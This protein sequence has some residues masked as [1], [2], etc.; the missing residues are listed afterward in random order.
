MPTTKLIGAKS[1]VLKDGND[2]VDPSI[3][4]ASRFA[5]S[6]ASLLHVLVNE[7]TRPAFVRPSC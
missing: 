3:D 2:G 5:P 7:V 1:A 6:H 4:S